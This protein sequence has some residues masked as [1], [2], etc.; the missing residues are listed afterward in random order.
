MKKLS[1][2]TSVYKSEK[3]LDLYLKNITSLKGFNDFTIILVLNEPND[4]ELE[5][6]KSYKNSFRDNVISLEVL[7]ESIA[8]STNRGFSMATTEFVTYADVDDYKYL[9][10]YS[11]QMETLINN[12]EIDFTYGDFIIT[13]KQGVFEGLLIKSPSFT[14]EIATRSSIVGP[15][16]FF[17]RKI[18]NTCGYWDE[19]FKSGGDFDF[20]IRAAL[21]VNF[22]KTH[23][24]PLLY[25]T[26][27]DDSGSAS[28]G[29]LQKIERTVIELRYGIYDK[30]NY[31]YLPKALEYDIYH[32]YYNGE[33]NI[34]AN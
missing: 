24:D 9:D 17:R 5:I 27:Y 26:R 11:R 16:H 32:V 30:I 2:I 12:P 4:N 10:C 6:L 34:L 21:N 25:Y 19:Q 23:G 18:L 13:S 8:S 14:K 15:N 3:Y 29:D 28:S 31:K 22:K 7:R 20:Q 33:K 1:I